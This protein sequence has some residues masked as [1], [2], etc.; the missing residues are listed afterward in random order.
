MQTLSRNDPPPPRVDAAL[1]CSERDLWRQRSLL[2][3][4]RVV[5]CL[6]TDTEDF[7]VRPKWRHFCDVDF[8][9]FSR[10]MERVTLFMFLPATVIHSI[11]AAANQQAT[12]WLTNTEG[13]SKML[14][15]FFFF[16]CCILEY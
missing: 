7:C 13:F 4:H 12:V 3:L 9:I 5:V 6:A 15:F 16:F 1:T 8:V 11:R 2:S 10:R 14:I